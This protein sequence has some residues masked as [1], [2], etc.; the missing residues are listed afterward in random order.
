VAA[1]VLA[2]TDYLRHRDVLLR[3]GDGGG[4]DAAGSNAADAAADA[5]SGDLALS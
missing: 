4:A 1:A 2:I 3:S 5:S